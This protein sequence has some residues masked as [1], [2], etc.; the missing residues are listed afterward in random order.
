MLLNFRCRD[1]T[2]TAKV[3]QPIP[4]SQ[5][6]VIGILLVIIL[7]GF[8]LRLLYAERPYFHPDEYVSMLAAKMVAER[9]API[10]PSGLWYDPEIPFSYFS[11]F[12]VW[13]LG[14]SN[15]TARWASVFFGIL[16]I[17]MAYTTTR[18]IFSSSFA[19]VTGA[20]LVAFAPEAVL[21]GARARRY[22]MGEFLVLLMLLLA[23]IGFVEGS[24][25]KYRIFFYLVYLVAG[26]T[27]AQTLIVVPPLLLAMVLL[28]WRRGGNRR[29]LK[30]GI[31]TEAAI[32][33]LLS[34]F[35]LWKAKFNFVV[36]YATGFAAE[37]IQQG[38]T[39]L[40]SETVAQVNPFLVPAFDWDSSISRIQGLILL[41]PLYKVLALPAL[42]AVILSLIRTLDNVKRFRRAIWFLL[43]MAGGV[44]SEFLFLVSEDW[45]GPRPRYLFV[46]F[47]P[48]FMMLACG[49]VV[50]LEKLI[51]HL[52]A[53]AN[54]SRY[55]EWIFLP[56]KLAP[57]L[58]FL[59][60]MLPSTTE[61]LTHGL[62]DEIN[63][64]QAFQ[65]VAGKWNAGDKVMSVLTTASYWYLG[66][67]DY[68][69][70]DKDP[71]VFQKGNSEFVDRWTGARWVSQPK[72]LT[73]ILPN[74]HVWFVIDASR[75][76]NVYSL[77][78]KQQLLAQM[79]PVYQTGNVYVLIPKAEAPV[80]PTQP[81]VQL[82]ARLAEQAELI[83]FSLDQE[84]LLAGSPAQLTLFWK[85]LKPMGDYK[86]FVHLRDHNNQVVAQADHIPSEKLVALPTSIWRVG[87]V[88]PDVSYLTVSPD[89]PPGN[90]DLLVGMYDPE[91][92]ERL[93][94]ENDRTG[95]N[96]VVLATWQRP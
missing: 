68:Y 73:E 55:A 25:R 85:A 29:I 86:I 24:K 38:D 14:A 18:R 43:I 40:L 54:I 15:F 93:P 21:W 81:E 20:A 4:A 80:I 82:D 28:T 6:L 79:K 69:A 2:R 10:L 63:Y 57:C 26:L 83:G 49:I 76:W 59:A 71:F 70:R 84:A 50:G 12:W 7:A 9:G 58:V 74:N 89:I 44:A 96:A 41:V 37:R 78:F 62:W 33:L 92:L 3:Q 67:A 31:L 46:T 95:E 77:A 35:L 51:W 56:V 22:G 64:H 23:W 61:S 36:P 48:A 8:R 16:S 94:V 11:G 52:N 32:M 60:F 1:S 17:P 45:T 42:L 53:R 5:M 13:L 47:W 19:G 87:E 72:E 66:R 75:L 88:V 39:S 91:T 27:V 65:F 30:R 90:Y 34:L